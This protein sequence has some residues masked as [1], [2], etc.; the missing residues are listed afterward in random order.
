[1]RDIT[2]EQCLMRVFIGESDRYR[3]RPLSEALVN[4]FR[5]NGFAGVTVLHGVAGY[6][7]HSVYHTDKLLEL[8]TDL[9][10][11]IEVVENRDRIDLVMPEIDAM[12]SGGMI[13]LEKIEVIRYRH[14][15]K[16]EE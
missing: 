10:I 14:H 15:G 16:G 7:A 12:M 3:H 5:K 2:G 13:T 1:M 6:G 11:I 9:P 4:L 8:S